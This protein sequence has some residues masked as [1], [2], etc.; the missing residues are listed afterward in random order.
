MVRSEPLWDQRLEF[1]IHVADLPRMSRLC[2]AL[3]A[4]IEKAKKP[5]GTK[6]KNKKA[7]GSRMFITVTHN[8]TLIRA[9]VCQLNQGGTGERCIC[10]VWILSAST[11]R[12]VSSQRRVCCR[13]CV[14][15]VVVVCVYTCIFFP[16]LLLLVRLAAASMFSGNAAVICSSA[17]SLLSSCRAEEGR[18]L[19]ELHFSRNPKFGL[20]NRL[21]TFTGRTHRSCFFFFLIPKF[22]IFFFYQWS[23]CGNTSSEKH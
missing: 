13:G 11:N 23:K 15:V 12:S 2:F 3:Y 10:Y 16:P 18:E 4:V 1:D 7:V 6:K 5:R 9:L 20:C 19:P 14:G 21:Y 17:L 22:F 8:H